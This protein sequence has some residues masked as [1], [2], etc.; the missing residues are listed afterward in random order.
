MISAKST[1]KLNMAKI[2]ELT[3]AQTTALEHTA[4]LLHEEVKQA[5]VIPF[6]SGNLQGESMFVD[7]SESKSGK[8]TIVHSTPYAR[9]LYFHPEYHFSTDENPDAKGKWFEDWEPGG[10][11]SQFAVDAYKK[12]YRRLSG[13]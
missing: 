13:V 7:Y 11:K 3:Q 12:I 5:Q 4:E 9:R 6:D 8:V 2:R 10:K 1:I